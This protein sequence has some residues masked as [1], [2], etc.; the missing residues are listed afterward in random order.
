MKRRKF[1]Q[2]LVGGSALG[3]TGW[4][5]NS[6]WP[7]LTPEFNL[8]SAPVKVSR[9]AHALGT[10]V[11]LTVF[12]RDALVAEA[13]I[14]QAFKEI[15]VV[16]QLMSIYRPDS[17]LSQLN[18]SGKLNH[19][20]PSLL[21]VLQTALQVS[22]ETDGAFDVT[23]QPL[24]QLYA[25]HAEKGSSPDDRSIRQTLQRVDWRQVEI[26]NE[27]IRLHGDNTAITLNGIAQGF[28][29]DAVAKVLQAHRIEHALIDSGE[30]G[31]L[32]KH[33]E[34]RDWSI[35]I[36]H[37]RKPDDFLGLAKL[38]GRCLATSGD[39]ET[40]F[41]EGYRNHHL[42]DPRTG[43]SANEL[44]SVSIAAPTAI[45]ADALSTAVFILGL[46]EGKKL[47]ESTLDVDALF[48]TRKGEIISTPE[49]PF[50]S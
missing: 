26:S 7:A 4:K 2:S 16:E 44:S 28:A 1:I 19:P 48:V 5:L 50:I 49:F 34:N 35:A 23:I 29:S 27:R 20:H 11:S 32:G 45:Q 38:Q 13:A 24:Y 12:H 40:R 41:G 30:I 8:T 37:P 42:L 14:D 3:W 6:Y 33:A 31:T 47:I 18:Q 17:Q 22:K 46:R 43:R 21:K 39:Y 9:G 36:K 10:Q 15:E 25:R